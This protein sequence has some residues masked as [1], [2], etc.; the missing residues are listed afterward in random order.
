MRVAVAGLGTMQAMMYGMGLYLGAFQGIA[1]EHRD[2]LRWISG[3]VTTPVFFYAGW[4]FYQAA[5]KALR[6]AITDCP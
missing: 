6:A 1:D 3:L 5:V 4:P 2:Y